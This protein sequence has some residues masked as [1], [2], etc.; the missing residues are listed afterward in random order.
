MGNPFAENS[1]DLLVLDNIDLADSAVIDAVRNTE[2]L[3]QDQYD[4]NGRLVDQTKPITDPIKRNSLPLF[5]RPPV[6][7]TGVIPEE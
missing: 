3:G 7:N 6:E 5:S 1:N 2:A 4:V